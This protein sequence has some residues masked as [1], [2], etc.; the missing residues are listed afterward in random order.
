MQDGLKTIEHRLETP[1]RITSLP[2]RGA[3]IQH[4]QKLRG[5]LEY[6]HSFDLD[7]ALGD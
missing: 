5:A 2:E 6:A 7:V 3:M 1:A 4:L